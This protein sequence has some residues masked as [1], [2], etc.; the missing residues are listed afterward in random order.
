MKKAQILVATHKAYE[1]PETDIYCPIQV[2]AAFGSNDLGVLSDDKGDH[3]SLKNHSFCELT[4]LYWAWKNGFFEQSEYSGLV[5][6]RRYF[7]GKQY[8][9]K[10]ESIL[11]E[12]EVAAY[13]N[14]A[15][16]ILPKKRNYYIE[17]VYSHYKHAHHIQDLDRAIAILI[18]KNPSYLT[19]CNQ[20]LKARKLHLFN[21]FVMKS[22]LCEKYCEWLFP[23]LFEL[24]SQI[25]ISSYTPYQRRVFGFIAERLF[26]IWIVHN[27]LRIS[28]CDVVSLERE[29]LFLKGFNFL[30]RK[31]FNDKK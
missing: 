25:D 29:N 14:K 22:T 2:G 4:A 9:I 6:Y 26:N 18:A 10:N 20:V 23:I 15:D 19:A 1:F 27:N 31:I 16:C 17:T 3:I 11:G 24:E 8:K 7:T 13:L 5:H 21:M 12:A 28:I 30:K